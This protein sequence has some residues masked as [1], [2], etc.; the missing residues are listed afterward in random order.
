M[1][2]QR[3]SF[4]IDR[5]SYDGRQSYCNP[6]QKQIRRIYVEKNPEKQYY[7]RRKNQYK[8]QYGITIADYDKMFIQQKGLCQICKQSQQHKR[9]AV[10]HCHITKNIRGLLCDSCN[11][12]IGLLKDDLAI[13]QNAVKYIKKNIKNEN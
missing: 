7:W 4:N 2:K 8:L 10:D 11:R 6:C 12:G 13:L 1:D 9:L 5:S 3:S